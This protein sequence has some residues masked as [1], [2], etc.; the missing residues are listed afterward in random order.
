M[1][2]EFQSKLDAVELRLAD[3]IDSISD[4]VHDLDK[5]LQA[6]ELQSFGGSRKLAS[7]EGQ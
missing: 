3:K 7:T 6:M 1:T 4:R 2:R 5:R